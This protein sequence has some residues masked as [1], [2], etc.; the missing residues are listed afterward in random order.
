[1][2][3]S[4][5]TVVLAGFF[6]RVSVELVMLGL[7]MVLVF[8]GG[9]YYWFRR[10]K[11]KRTLNRQ[12]DAEQLP[13]QHRDGQNSVP[14]RTRAWG[15]PTEAKWLMALATAV[16][17]YI[18]F[19]VYAYLRT[20]SPTQ[21]FYSE[22]AAAVVL[23]TVAMVGGFKFKSYVDAKYGRLEV[24]VES[25][26]DEQDATV[27]TETRTIYFHVDDVIHSDQG[28]AVNRYSDSRFLFIFRLPMR[29]ADI[30]RLREDE[31]V[32]KPAKEQATY[33]VP[34]RAHELQPNVYTFRTKGEKT[35]E[36]STTEIDIQWEPAFSMSYE[37]KKRREQ[38]REKLLADVRE[39]NATNARL[40]RQVE[41]LEAALA[42]AYEENFEQFMDIAE[43]MKDLVNGSGSTRS[44]EVTV[45]RSL[46]TEGDGRSARNNGAFGEAGDTTHSE[47]TA[48]RSGGDR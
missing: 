31:D 14:L 39:T 22:Q 36:S 8:A 2:I 47:A 3:G 5:P 10:R 13:Q 29:H 19:Q 46:L 23:V 12:T 18:G 4:P 28:L 6:S 34:D 21:S 11:A 40:S 42:A 32:T 27:A 25:V 9:A 17:F 45:P 30:A 16:L 43:E 35:S 20:G 38:D 48:G 26:P 37:E 33:A 24:V 7:V 1:M 15:T 44:D 41:K